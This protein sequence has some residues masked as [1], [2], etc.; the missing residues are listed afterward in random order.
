ML[1]KSGSDRDRIVVEKTREVR[2]VRDHSFICKM[3]AAIDFEL[4]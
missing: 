1:H 4:R 2:H 3:V